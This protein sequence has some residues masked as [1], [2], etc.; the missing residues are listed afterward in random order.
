MINFLHTFQP[1]STL[2]NIGPINI[3]WYGLFLVLG[4]LSGILIILKLAEHYELSKDMLIDL[5]FWLIIGGIIGARIYDVLLEFGYYREHLME[6]VKIWQGGLAIHGAIIAGIIILYYFCKRQKL[7]FWMISS[8][9]TPGIAIGQAIGRWG[10]YFNQELFGKPTSLPWG[11]P[12]NSFNRP[13]QYFTEN[14]FQPAFLYESIGNLIIFLF[15]FFLHYRKIKNGKGDFGKITLT[16][17]ILYS[18]LRFF[19]EFIRIDATP[20]FLNLRFPQIISIVIVI[21]SV[22]YW[23][24]YRSEAL[25]NKEMNN[26]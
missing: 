3:Y 24:F 18:I 8:I 11:I 2:L 20:T 4:M 16:Y 6:I 26:T 10:N 22:F 25:N 1:N 21:L 12:I 5:I 7:D 17:L 9:L 23:R 19:M 15:L 13:I 14:Y